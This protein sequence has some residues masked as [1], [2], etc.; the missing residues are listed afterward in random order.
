M[1]R[2]RINLGLKQR[3]GH[4]ALLKAVEDV[5]NKKYTMRKASEIYK[6]PL[7]TLCDNVNGKSQ[8]NKIGAKPKLNTQT[9]EILADYFSQLIQSGFNPTY[10]HVNRIISEFLVEHNLR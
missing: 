7:S 2:K 6:V 10:N 9:E 3:Y 8:S 4:E 1:P 5:R